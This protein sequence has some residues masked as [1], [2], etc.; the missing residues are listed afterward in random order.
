MI[1]VHAALMLHEGGK[2]INEDNIKNVIQS[3]GAQVDD[4][5][6]KALVASL[7]DVNI[8]EA[9]KEAVSVAAQPAAEEGEKK[10][11]E[12]SEED[13]AKAAESASAGLSGLFG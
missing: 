9:L 4:S 8:D 11:E 10:K 3:V 6:V 12:E 2:E 5:K 1:E 13:K 7:K